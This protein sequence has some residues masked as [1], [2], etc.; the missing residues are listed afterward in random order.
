MATV[1]STAGKSAT[2]RTEA[3]EMSQEARGD[4]EPVLPSPRVGKNTSD[5][6][7]STGA[8]TKLR[9]GC[10]TPVFTELSMAH[11]QQSM[12][13]VNIYYLKD[14]VLPKSSHIH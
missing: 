6:S 11:I 2:N 7:V 13:T 1:Y 5:N 3:A 12:C 10:I 4:G 9:A 8:A 14:I